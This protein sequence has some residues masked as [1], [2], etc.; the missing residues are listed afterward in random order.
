[1]CSEIFSNPQT[2]KQWFSQIPLLTIITN[3]SNLP[4]F[5]GLFSQRNNIVFCL[6]FNSLTRVIPN[7]R[8]KQRT[9]KLHWDQVLDS[10]QTHSPYWWLV[11]EYHLHSSYS[12]WN[13]ISAK[14][15]LYYLNTLVYLLKVKSSNCHYSFRPLT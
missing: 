4:P 1:M 3:S 13:C 9:E 10:Y 7:I 15:K 6:C 8:T 5:L 2:W 14:L 12:L 11:L